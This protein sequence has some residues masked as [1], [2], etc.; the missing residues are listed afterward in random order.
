MEF[1]GALWAVP[2]LGIIFSM[3][4]L[5]LLCPKLWEK[6]GC[7]VPLFWSGAYLSAVAI[8]FGPG[9]I[10]PAVWEPILTDYLPFIIL[11]SALYIVSGGIFVDF[12]RGRGYIFN[13]LFL[14]FGSVIAGWIGTTGAAALLIRPF[15]RANTGRLHTTH[16]PVF[17][18]L[19]VAN[20]GGA[21]TPLGDPPL[22]IG[23]LKGIDFFWFVKKLY[24]FSLGTLTFLSLLFLV[25]DY[26]CFKADKEISRPQ[27]N[28]PSI[29]VEGMMNIIL[30]AIILAAV[31]FCNFEGTF[32]LL[33][34][35][36]SISSLLRNTILSAIS[37]ISLKF[38]P[39]EIREKNSFSVAPIREIAELFAG[40]FITVVPIIRIL[41]LGSSG[42]FGCLFDWIAPGG[43]FVVDRCFWACGTLSSFLDNAP[44]FLIFFH[45]TSGDPNILMT[46]KSNLLTAFSVSSVFMGAMTYIGNAPN[47][48]VRSISVSYGLKVPSFLGYMVWSMALLAPIF[49]VISYFL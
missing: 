13:T 33:G 32:T 10:V 35:K 8:C 14:F 1:T 21:A 31:I 26:I 34:E 25:T 40:I 17:F 44:T 23:F 46:V 18:I 3:S 45:L 27:T 19:M 15:L 2:F 30:T 49:I 36:F 6:Y 24:P 38:T 22:F 7:F 28:E 48:I 11:I 39:P 43:E 47:L 42:A 29:R 20:I 16:L 41:H 4:F 5:P 12:P 9:E 37:I